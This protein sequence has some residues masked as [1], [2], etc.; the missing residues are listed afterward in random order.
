MT[1]PT[2][3][4]EIER[5]VR[6]SHA[7]TG[8]AL[9][10]L[11]DHCDQLDKTAAKRSTRLAFDLMRAVREDGR[12]APCRLRTTAAHAH[13]PHGPR[14]QAPR[15]PPTLS[16]KAPRPYSGLSARPFNNGARY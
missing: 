9:Q 2:R 6:Q 13:P 5:V 7:A 3:E 11:L 12:A 1:E 10:A 14:L 16:R 8:A 4:A 15:R